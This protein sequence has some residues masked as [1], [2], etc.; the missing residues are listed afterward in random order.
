MCLD[1]AAQVV[2]CDGSLAVVDIEGR[3]HRASTLLLPDV[4]P[5]DWVRVAVGT[6]FERIDADQAALINDELRSIQE[7]S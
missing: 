4:R 2:S 5:G 3:R 1:F 6:I 7:V